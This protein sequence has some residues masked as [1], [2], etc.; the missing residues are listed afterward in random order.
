MATLTEAVLSGS[1]DLEDERAHFLFRGGGLNLYERLLG[2]TD[3]HRGVKVVY[4]NGDVLVMARTRQHDRIGHRVNHLVFELARAAGVPCEDAGETTYRRPPHVAGAQ[5]DDAFYFRG[6]AEHMAGQKDDDPATDPVPDLVLE[7]EVHHP[8]TFALAAW[9]RLGVAEVWH[10][11][12]RTKKLGLQVLR[13]A[14]D[15]RVYAPVTRSGVLPFDDAEILGLL[16]SSVDEVASVWYDR[17]PE[18]I[19]AVMAARG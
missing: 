1:F 2:W 9:A 15:G 4:L 7:V 8:V 14:D 13:L 16:R 19:A 10:V 18:R 11:N 6:N 17:L 5:G 12:A 3:E